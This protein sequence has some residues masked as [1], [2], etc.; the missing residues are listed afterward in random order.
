MIN[1]F[2]RKKPAVRTLDLTGKTPVIRCSIC[3]GEQ[4][5]GV[6]DNE[7]GVFTEVMRIVTEQDYEEFCAMCRTD[8]IERIY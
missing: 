5:A 6:R 2:Q 3:T 1:P 4:T 8:Q 7:T